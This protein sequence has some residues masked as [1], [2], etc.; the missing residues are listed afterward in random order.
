L[1]AHQDQAATSG[2]VGSTRQVFRSPVAIA[3]W[4][5]WV[6]FAVANLIDLAV[7]GHDHISLVAAVILILITGVMY[8]AVL[9]PRVIA[10]DEAL[11]IVN[12]LRD[13]RIGWSTVA[14]ADP[15]DLVRVRCEWPAGRKA[16][17]AWAIYS[18]RRRQFAAEMRAQRLTRAR[19]QTASRGYGAPVQANDASKTSNEPNDSERVVAAITARLDESR[20]RADTSRADTALAGGQAEVR[21]PL[22]TWHWR[23]VAAIVIPALA[24]L[25]VILA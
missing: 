25:I 1:T 2:Q 19:P 23:S 18:S 13:H 12:P 8:A 3:V 5:I 11:T 22:S 6:L 14:G 4:W 20:A 21:P 16:I 15:T 7:Q 10:E 17:Y 24:L 9:R